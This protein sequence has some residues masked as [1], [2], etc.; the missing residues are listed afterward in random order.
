MYQTPISGELWQGD[1]IFGGAFPVPTS[2]RFSEGEVETNWKIKR[3]PLAIVSHS[4]DVELHNGQPK[5]VAVQLTPLISPPKNLARNAEALSLLREHSVV[6]PARPA[7]LNLFLFAPQPR[8]LEVEM[9]ADL[10]VIYSFPMSPSLHAELLRG[11]R[12]EL[13]PEV[14]LRLQEKLML[15]YGREFEAR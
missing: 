12:L 14:R 5:R 11:K 8:V 9:L 15:Q 7:H 6:N 3:C 10:S 2:L 4:C 13:T 1:V